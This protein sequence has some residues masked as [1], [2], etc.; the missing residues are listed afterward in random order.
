MNFS[1]CFASRGRVPLLRNLF[2]SIA[3]NSKFLDKVEVL[4][5]IDNDD[6]ATC[7]A[8][9]QLTTRFPF[10]QFFRRDRS[11]MLNR[12]YINWVYDISGRKGD[13][14]I[15]CNDDA[16]F[17]TKNWDEIL[18]NKFNDFIKDKPDGVVYG[19]TTDTI[20]NRFNMGYCC[21]PTL[22]KR[23]VEALGWIMPPE[24]HSWVADISCWR[25]YH[26]VGRICDVSEV[27]IEHISYHSGKRGRDETSY[28]VERIAN[29][30]ASFDFNSAVSR[31]QQYINNAQ[32][33]V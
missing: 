22:S 32:I 2:D 33:K 11:H 6:T 15:A 26:A 9:D 25:V 18:L 29:H 12:D 1:I 23:G 21:F 24:Y 5:G 3:G 10:V 17:A 31:M 4:V 27:S 28:H 20:L 13:Y 14:V 7:N 8:V 19:Y 30:N 16:I